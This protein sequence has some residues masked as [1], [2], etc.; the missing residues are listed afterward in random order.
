MYP[1]MN[2]LH[3]ILRWLIVL[4][5]LF[6]IIRAVTG[7]SFKRGWMKMDNNAGMW[8]TMLL[9]V[10]VLVGIILY[11][12]LSPTTKIA[13][14]NFGGAMGNPVIRFFAVEHGL[15]MLV[16]VVVAHVGRSL[17]QRAPNE[18][19]KHRRSITWTVVSLLIVLAS[20]PWPF[21]TAGQGR[22][23]F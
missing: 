11:F 7:I 13:L 12:F 3:S 6:V 16:A 20:V 14:Q 1:V 22:G 8:Y 15:G 17:V 10:Q 21:L 5:A 23:W 4:A 9:D 19:Q 18:M 2:T